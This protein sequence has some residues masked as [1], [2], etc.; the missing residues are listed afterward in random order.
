MDTRTTLDGLGRQQISQTLQKQGSSTYDSVE[1]DYDS[2]GRPYRVT[3][4]YA[5]AAGNLSSGAATVTTYDGLSRPTQVAQKNSGGGAIGWTNYTYSQNDVLVEVAP[6]P[7]GEHTKRR[8]LEYDALGRLTSV[9]EISDSS[10]GGSPLPGA[11]A[12]NQNV[13][14]NGFLT[15]YTWD[16]LGNLLTVSQNAQSGAGTTQSRTYLYDGL[17]RMTQ[18][19]NPELYG[20][21]VAYKY[22]SDSTC[23]TSNGDLVKRTDPLQPVNDVT[24]YGYDTLHR[25]TA[26]TYP[27]GSYSAVTPAKHYVYDSA[28]VNGTGMTYAKGRLAE[29]YTGASKTTDLGYSYSL[30]G[31]VTDV[32]QSTPNSG[33]YYHVSA[34]YWANGLVNT[35]S[36]RLSGPPA[37]WT[38]TPEGE[39]RLYSISAGSTTIASLPSLTPYNV[40]GSPLGITYGSGDSDAFTYDPNTG[41][42]TGFSGTLGVSPWVSLTVSGAQSGSSYF[43]TDQFTVNIKGAPSTPVYVNQ[44]NG[45]NFQVGTTLA[46]G[47]LAVPGSWTS[48]NVGTYT[49]V[50]SVGSTAATPTLNFNV[51]STT[52]TPAGPTTSTLGPSPSAI[53]TWNGNGSLGQVALMD[54]FNSGNAQTCA[55][56]HDDLARI[57]GV[58]C[59]SGAGKWNQ[60]FNY[61]SDN[62]GNVNWSGSSRFAFS[63]D[64]SNHF[65]PS[66]SPVPAYDGNGNLTSDGAHSYTWD[67]DGNLNKLDSAAAIVYDALDR[68]VEQPSGGGTAEIL[69]GP[70][71]SKLA[72]MAGQTVTRAFLALPGGATAVYNSSGLAWYRHPDWLGSS[73]LASTPA[74][75]TM[76]YDAA[77]SPQGEIVSQAGTADRNFTGQNQDLNPGGDLYDF[78]NREYH[79]SHGRWISPDPAGLAAVNPANPQSWNRYAYVNGSPL[80]SVD[81]LGLATLWQDPG[82]GCVPH[83]ACADQA[84][85]TQMPWRQFYAGGGAYNISLTGAGTATFWSTPDGPAI[86]VTVLGETTGWDVPA[87]DPSL[88]MNS[89]SGGGG[90]MQGGG[91][92]V[93]NNGRNCTVGSASARQYAAATAQVA[94]MTAQFFS[95]LGNANQTFGPG[96]ATSQVMAQSAGV[97]DALNEYYMTGATHDLYT[98][99]GAGYVNAGANP[100]AQF[101]GSFRWSISGGILSLTN[102]TSF[103]SLTYDTGP[104]WQRSSFG[105]MGNTYQTYQISVTC[106]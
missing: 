50:W 32:Y 27:S 68:R 48:A 56:S 81:P 63:Y 18:E 39:G 74:T 11:G 55:Y 104:Q 67:A 65:S 25:V 97:H 101:V 34:T 49:Q 95:G 41:A 72:V 15:K 21:A 24:C 94:A 102:T 90:G 88:I 3:I 22:D 71:G 98:F 16:P 84:Q 35:L 79:A 12:C 59:G 93:A 83:S 13:A 89:L 7:S 73:R 17:G 31:E 70:G 8:Q 37:S 40:F 14:Q 47:T 76:Y 78:P 10:Q 96:T 87:G 52:P 62:F 26:V 45:G 6:A 92:A 106:H 29:A 75:R 66:N 53:L 60:T 100:V 77:Y 58:N 82:P 105:P 38:F 43:D 51:V 61:G 23:G 103:K 5:A 33:G 44:N 4:P 42:M 64:S 86:S 36:P 9:C 54:G 80:N 57:S 46:D 69:Y 30:R 2:V 28:T 19:N 1:T 91:G 20:A 85:Q 99:G